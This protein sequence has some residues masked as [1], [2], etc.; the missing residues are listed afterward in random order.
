MSAF[1]AQS[2][3]NGRGTADVRTGRRG[4]PWERT[5]SIRLSDLAAMILTIEIVHLWGEAQRSAAS[6]LDEL[7]YSAGAFNLSL[8][9]GCLN[10]LGGMIMAR[11]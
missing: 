2:R 3:R 10:S 11:N 4:N 5:V 1:I 7:E 6:I 9:V 8:A